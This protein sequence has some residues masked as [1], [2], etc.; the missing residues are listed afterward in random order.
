MIYILALNV[1]TAHIYIG[2]VHQL[3]VI[4]F[5]SY[6]GSFAYNSWVV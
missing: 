4:E 6:E 5:V 2:S 1:E 3:I